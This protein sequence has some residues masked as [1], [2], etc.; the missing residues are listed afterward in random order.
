MIAETMGSRTRPVGI[1]PTSGG[2]S[3]ESGRASDHVTTESDERELEHAE[4]RPLKEVERQAILV[5][6]KRLGVHGAAAV[7]GI[8][9]T[10]IHRKLRD[11]RKHDAEPDPRW[12]AVPL[13]KVNELLTAAAKATEFLKWCQGA[14][15]PRLGQQL[16][17]AVEDFR[18]LCMT[19]PH[20][21]KQSVAVRRRKTLRVR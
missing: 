18:K 21:R 19:S 4:I 12:R 10:T 13:T 8:G 11:Y 16:G 3:T 15:A 5:A 17:A 9:K 20:Q 7:L 14:M 6:V 2:S 1:Q